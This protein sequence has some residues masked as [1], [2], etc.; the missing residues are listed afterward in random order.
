[1]SEGSSIKFADLDR[2]V[3]SV[4]GDK[5]NR[6]G[7]DDV[8]VNEEGDGEVSQNGKQDGEVNLNGEHGDADSLNGERSDEDSLNGEQGNTAVEGKGKE[9]LGIQDKYPDD[10]SWPSDTDEEKE[11]A[12]YL[13]V[14]KD[15]K[16]LELS[17][18]A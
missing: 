2:E 16:D 9:K 7:I 13:A 8:K 1:M 14:R 11:D 6:E 15:K 18:G 17:T 12:K 4:E 3:D 10:P 5:G